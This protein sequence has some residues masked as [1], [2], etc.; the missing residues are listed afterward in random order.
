MNYLQTLDKYLVNDLK[1]KVFEIRG[2]AIHTELM[3]EIIREEEIEDEYIQFWINWNYMQVRKGEIQW[4]GGA[5]HMINEFD[6]YNDDGYDPI[7]K[8]LYPE[9]IKANRFGPI[10][11]LGD[12]EGYCECWCCCNL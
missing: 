4:N 1:S 11:C 8:P 2:K 10:I 7:W 6:D 9:Y 3:N 12:S 5:N